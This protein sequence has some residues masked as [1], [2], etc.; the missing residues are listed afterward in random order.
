MAHHCTVMVSATA[1]Y[2]QAVNPVAEAESAPAHLTLL[3]PA[4]KLKIEPKIAGVP[5][6]AVGKVTAEET[7]VPPAPMT[8]EV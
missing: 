8:I 1:E 2:A 3:P 5:E 6:K 7:A 4:V